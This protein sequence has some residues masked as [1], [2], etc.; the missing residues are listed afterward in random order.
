MKLFFR[1]QAIYYKNHI[2]TF[3]LIFTAISLIIFTLAIYVYTP[4]DLYL[5]KATLPLGMLQFFACLFSILNVVVIMNFRTAKKEHLSKKALLFQIVFYVFIVVQLVNDVY[6]I[7]EI[8]R[9]INEGILQT[10]FIN[11]PAKS[12]VLFTYLHIVFVALSALTL[13]FAPLIQKYTSRIKL[14]PVSNQDK[15]LQ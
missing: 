14:K 2:D 13:A 9:H 1:R 10:K 8:N 6:Y 15:D 3:A 5:T 11:Y 7:Y 4:L 12:G